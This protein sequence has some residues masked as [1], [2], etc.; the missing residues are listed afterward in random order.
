MIVI[1]E[2]RLPEFCPKVIGFYTS[3]HYSVLYD[4]LSPDFAKCRLYVIRI[5]IKWLT[6]RFYTN[7]FSDEIYLHTNTADK[8]SPNVIKRFPFFLSRYAMRILILIRRRG[9]GALVLCFD[10]ICKYYRF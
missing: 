4:T 6:K 9:I 8:N 5:R 7:A 10:C 3:C 2:N 1:K